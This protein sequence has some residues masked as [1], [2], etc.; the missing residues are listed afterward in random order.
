MKLTKISWLVLTIG[1]LVITFASLGAARSKQINERTQVSD[2]L[3]V[4]ELRLN[5]FQLQQL[6]SQQASL[7]THLNQTIAQLKTAKTMLSQPN[8]SIIVSDA[9]FRIAEASGVEVID[10]SSSTLTDG[11]LEGVTCSVL[12]LSTTVSGDVPN[13]ISFII[14]LNNDFTTGTVKSAQI[15]ISV[16][17]D[18]ATADARVSAN[19]QMII[20]SYLGD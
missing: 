10:I 9:V 1:I 12:P 13:L 14:K 6:Y 19:I 4:A 17:T 15:T 5:Q 20:Y 8:E 2:E 7:E 11:K 3:A 18:N 16:P